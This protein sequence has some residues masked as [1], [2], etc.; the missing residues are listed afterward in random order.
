MNFIKYIF[1]TP[2]IILCIIL[3]LKSEENHDEKD[4]MDSYRIEKAKHEALL[5]HEFLLNSQKRILRSEAFEEEKI[6]V[7]VLGT[8]YFDDVVVFSKKTL[9]TLKPTDVSSTVKIKAIF[10][11]NRL[12]GL[13]C[14]TFYSDNTTGPDYACIF[15]KNGKYLGIAQVKSTDKN[16]FR[17]LSTQKP[18]ARTQTYINIAKRLYIAW[19]NRKKKMVMTTSNQY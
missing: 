9:S 6:K 19:Q 17:F 10:N 15:G 12:V 16:Y 13:Y 14:Y 4:L 5:Q 1:I 7:D 18:S 8:H 11:K 3:P 2:A